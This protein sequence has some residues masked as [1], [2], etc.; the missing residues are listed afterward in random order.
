MYKFGSIVLIP[1]PF[2]DLTSSK[3]RP[4]LIISQNNES[5]E[6]ILVSF[7]S[8]KISKNSNTILI[9]HNSPEFISSGLKKDSEVRLDKI[10]TLRK[11]LIL[12][13]LGKLSKTFL[14]NHKEKF[15]EIFGF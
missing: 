9:P 10:A 6:D 7:I 1:F 13:E 12:G 5:S 11:S 3:L 15:Y 2:T 8:S 14:N 4:A